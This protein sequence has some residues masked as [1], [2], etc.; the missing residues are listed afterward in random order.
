[1][2]VHGGGD[3]GMSCVQTALR[4]TGPQMESLLEGSLQQVGMGLKLS[5]N[6]IS[7]N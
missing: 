5:P 1:M 6:E 3:L 7:R 4:K 2:C